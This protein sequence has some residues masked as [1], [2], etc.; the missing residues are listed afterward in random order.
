MEYVCLCLERRL[1]EKIIWSNNVIFFMMWYI[2]D[3]MVIENS[4]ITSHWIYKKLNGPWQG[5]WQHCK[6]KPWN[7]NICLQLFPLYGQ[8][9]WG[10]TFNA[11]VSAKRSECK[12]D[13][14]GSRLSIYI[15]KYLLKKTML[16]R[17]NS[18]ISIIRIH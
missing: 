1:F 9:T 17:S 10:L 7:C 13:I 16:A 2:W 8:N 6:R 3:K 14:S 11:N 4:F 15:K 5:L 18:L 12:R